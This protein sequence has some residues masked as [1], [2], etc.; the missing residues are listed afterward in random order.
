MSDRAENTAKLAGATIWT[1][2][3]FFAATSG[4]ACALRIWF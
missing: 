4:I 2:L 3:K 1:F